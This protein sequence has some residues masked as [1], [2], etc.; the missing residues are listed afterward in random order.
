[1]KIRVKISRKS[2]EEEGCSAVESSETKKPPRTNLANHQ[3]LAKFHDSFASD[4]L[5]S[6]FNSSIASGSP[7]LTDSCGNFEHGSFRI[8]SPF[9]GGKEKD[10]VKVDLER[11]FGSNYVK[12]THATPPVATSSKNGSGTHCDDDA[13]KPKE[14]TRRRSRSRSR[15]R[16]STTP[17][18]TVKCS[19]F[20]QRRGDA[21]DFTLNLTE[22]SPSCRRQARRSKSLGFRTSDEIIQAYDD[23][24]KREIAQAERLEQVQC[25]P[26]RRRRASMSHGTVYDES[27]LVL[28]HERLI[29]HH[30]D[31]G[32]KDSKPTQQ[33]CK[34]G[35][36]RNSFTHARSI[37]ASNDDLLQAYEDI[38]SDFDKNV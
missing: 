7:I 36:P 27:H 4:T 38:V 35:I 30:V 2:K 23:L 10:K 6:S 33:Q 11:F 22:S 15:A 3:I 31:D 18:A 13:T 1:M 21:K 16:M 32:A 17:P 24:Q 5:H 34:G 29:N 8:R 14:C 9:S 37:S 25:E 12:S 28:D 19:H 26:V 20:F